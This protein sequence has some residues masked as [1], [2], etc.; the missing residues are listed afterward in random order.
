[1]PRPPRNLFLLTRGSSTRGALKT[2]IRSRLDLWIVH[3][4]QVFDLWI[5]LAWSLKNG[6]TLRTSSSFF[7][8]CDTAGLIGI[9]AFI[10]SGQESWGPRMRDFNVV[11]GPFLSQ[12]YLLITRLH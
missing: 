10:G 7:L 6:K 11:I 4:W 5:A 1:M 9:G 8:V 3:A 12:C 2:R